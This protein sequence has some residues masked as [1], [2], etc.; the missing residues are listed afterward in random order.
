M[1]SVP[2]ESRTKT[3]GPTSVAACRTVIEIPYLE[4]EVK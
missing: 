2:G 4:G 3:A 1:R